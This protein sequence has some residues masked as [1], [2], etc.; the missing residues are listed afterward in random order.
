VKNALN[1][2][3]TRILGFNEPEKS[4]QS[5]LAL[6]KA[7]QPSGHERRDAYGTRSTRS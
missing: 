2:G 7:R 4:G 1:S 6:Q 5:N 3:S